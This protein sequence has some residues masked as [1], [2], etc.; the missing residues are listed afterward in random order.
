MD[1]K[2]I[3]DFHN[4]Y[5][6]HL[7]S[8]KGKLHKPEVIRFEE[9]LS[10]ELWKMKVELESRSYQFSGYYHF[11]IYE[12]KKREIFAV[13]YRD[14]VIQHCICDEVLMPLITPRLIHDNAACQKGK[15]VHF[16]QKRLSKFLREHYRKHGKKGYVLK[17]DI[18][19][20][21]PSMSH[22]VLKAKVAKI[23]KDKEVQALL[24]QLIDGYHETKGTGLPL[25]NQTSQWF[26]IYYLDSLDRLIKEHLQI[27]HYTRYMD[28]FILLHHDKAHLQYCLEQIREHLEKLHLEL[29]K[30]T[31]IFPIRTG[32]E[33]IGFRFF[34]TENG[35]VI[36]RMKR[37]SKVRFKRRVATLQRNYAKGKLNLEEVKQS[38]AG[39]KGHL[40]HGHTYY[41]RKTVFRKFVLKRDSL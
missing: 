20:Y 38:L 6:A 22:E 15:G 3:C 19:R 9:N 36:R 34:L 25:G 27:K 39:F 40:K 26:A 28:D 1:Y 32:I 24:W 11:T 33:Y 17:C 41:L 13:Y 14:R 23:V 18:R 4:L 2:T 10:E 5:Q 16:A 31:Q 37:E 8:R 29:N 35:K 7:M 12:P 21:F 30:K